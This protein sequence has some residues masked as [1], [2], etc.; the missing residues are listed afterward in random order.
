VNFGLEL[1]GMGLQPTAPAGAVGGH[2]HGE[3]SGNSTSTSN[4]NSNNSS[5]AGLA[6]VGLN[7]N[8]PDARNAD[9]WASDLQHAATGASRLPDPAEDYAR[10]IGQA[11]HDA[12]P[13][14]PGTA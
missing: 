9:T 10:A 8:V 7:G 6:A 2:G 14:L 3:G 13:Q 11:A 4:S 12:P 5:H 1:L